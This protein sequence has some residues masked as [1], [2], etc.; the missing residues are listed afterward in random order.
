VI[1]H[2]GLNVPDLAAAKSYYDAFM[3]VLGFE[4]YLADDTQFAYR[5]AGGKP[6]TYLFFYPAP[7][8]AGY[9]RRRPGLQ[10]LAFVVP[11]RTLVHRVHD[12]A[13]ERGSEIAIAP[14]EFPEYPPPYFACFWRDPHGFMLEVV[15]HKDVD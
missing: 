3:P 11:T 8:P 13:V 1:G 10:H 14:Q 15:C 4:I 7:E 12:L 9:E 2:L 5:R 6:G